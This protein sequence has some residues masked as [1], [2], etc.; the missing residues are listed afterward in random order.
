MT[1]PLRL[2][3]L[4]L[5]ALALAA[6][7]AWAQRPMA[8]IR[9]APM[10]PSP[11]PGLQGPSGP[12]TSAADPLELLKQVNL[13]R[14]QVATLQQQVQALQAQT[15]GLQSQA[16]AQAKDIAGLNSGLKT[17]SVNGFANAG[18]ILAVKSDLAAAKTAMAS[19]LAAL[20]SSFN[21]HRHYQKLTH[22]DGSGHQI[23]DTIATTEPSFTCKKGNNGD[24]ICVAPD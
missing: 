14:G 16:A 15:G 21:T 22:Q 3:G 10:Q 1:K 12:M 8:P 5:A 2:L 24:Y 17:T 18:N 6:P 23:I 9:I 4:S 11:N 13:L 7:A 19:D 20:R